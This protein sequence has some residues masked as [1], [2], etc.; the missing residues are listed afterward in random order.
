MFMSHYATEVCKCPNILQ[1]FQII[2]GKLKRFYRLLSHNAENNGRR[3]V[4]PCSK[5][6]K[7]RQKSQT[8]NE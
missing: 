5:T 1:I 4:I 8:G 2:I 6:V 7:I 3:T